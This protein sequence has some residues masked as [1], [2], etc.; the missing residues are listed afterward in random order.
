MPFLV[1]IPGCFEYSGKC[2]QGV[3]KRVPSTLLGMQAGVATVENSME[4]P[5]KLKMELP[6]DP[7][8][9][10]LGI[11]PRKTETPTT[12]KDICIPMFIAAQ[13]TIAKIWK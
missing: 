13:C 3:G 2:W 9:P 6:F 10:L 1:P 11:Y 5:Q 12:R 7:I 8:I 4:I